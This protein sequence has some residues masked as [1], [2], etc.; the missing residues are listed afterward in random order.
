M[1]IATDRNSALYQAQKKSVFVAAILALFFGPLGM[2]YSTVLGAV[3]MFFVNLI[4]GVLT[5]GFGLILTWPIGVAWAAVAATR[6]N[7]MLAA[8]LA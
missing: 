5:A 4:V 2:F 8:A 7:T 6:K 1:A 3:V